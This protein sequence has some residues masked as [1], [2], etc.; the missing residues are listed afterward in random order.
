MPFSVYTSQDNHLIHLPLPGAIPD[1]INVF[2]QNHELV[3][4]AKI[5]KPDGD[6][7]L[8]ELPLDNI[9]KRIKLN[10]ATNEISAKYSDGLLAIT[11][12]K[13]ERQI[14]INIA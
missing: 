5:E 2:V 10:K 1:S 11:I 7:I 9:E 12:A 14:K 3:I 6:I 4:E 8:G 13:K